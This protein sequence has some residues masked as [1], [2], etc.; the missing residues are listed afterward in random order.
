MFI[1]EAIAKVVVSAVVRV[2]ENSP[3][4]NILEIELRIR[5]CSVKLK[6]LEV[7]HQEIKL[8]LKNEVSHRELHV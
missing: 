7:N 1:V 4:N 8:R 3:S 2:V 6:F 5:G